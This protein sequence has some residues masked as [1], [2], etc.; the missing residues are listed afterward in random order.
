MGVPA[1]E[2]RAV[3]PYGGVKNAA[4]EPREVARLRPCGLRSLTLG[5]DDH[6]RH[7]VRAGGRQYNSHA[8]ERIKQ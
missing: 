3:R 5:F 6:C 8:D 4:P 7:R 2:W 1:R